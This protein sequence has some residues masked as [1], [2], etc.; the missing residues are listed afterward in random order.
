MR[1]NSIGV[2]RIQSQDQTLGKVEVAPTQ[3]MFILG[4]A[5]ME[6]GI[7]CPSLC[8]QSWECVLSPSPMDI[9]I[10]VMLGHL[11]VLPSLLHRGVPVPWF[12]SLEVPPPWEFLPHWDSCPMVLPHWDS[13]S[14]VL[15]FCNSC[16]V[17]LLHWDSCSIGIPA[18]PCSVLE[19]IDPQDHPIPSHQIP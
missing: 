16:S 19:G 8:S 12:S 3:A 14:M 9:S 13:S 6:S 11:P 7:L 1:K 5:R 18:P 17:V 10:P 4:G 15:L 2:S